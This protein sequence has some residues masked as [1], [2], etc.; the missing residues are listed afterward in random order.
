MAEHLQRDPQAIVDRVQYLCNL[1]HF[2]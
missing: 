1:T 2:P